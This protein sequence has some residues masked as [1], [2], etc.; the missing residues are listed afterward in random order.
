VLAGADLGDE[1]G[2]GLLGFSSGSDA[3]AFLAL[4]A[5]DRVTA[6]VDDH[7]PALAPLVDHGGLLATRLTAGDCQWI[8][9][10]VSKAI[11]VGL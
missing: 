9:S 4:A 5:G 7:P 3:D 6:G 1:P 11:S 8:A 2:L 10:Q